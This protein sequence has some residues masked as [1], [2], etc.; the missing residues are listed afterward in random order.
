MSILSKITFIFFFL[1]GT[2]FLG[3]AFLHIRGWENAWTEIAANSFDLPFFVFAVL[4]F[5]FRVHDSLIK[6]KKNSKAATFLLA[7][8]AT[9]LIVALI[10]LNI[11]VKD[12]VR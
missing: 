1:T 11:G 3:G 5:V 6:L 10:Y 12:A 4:F 8:F 2:I 9:F 7:I